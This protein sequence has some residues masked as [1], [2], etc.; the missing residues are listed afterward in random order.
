[1]EMCDFSAIMAVIRAYISQDYIQNQVDFLYMLFGSF[2]A[3][4]ENA[5]FDFDNAL[6]CR[7]MNGTARVSPR[8]TSYYLNKTHRVELQKD[9]AQ[10]VLPLMYDSARA[11]E[12]LYELV[13]QDIDI[14][15]RQ[16][17]LLT[18]N[19]PCANAQEEAVFLTRLLCFAM[20][21]NFVKRDSGTKRLL[22]DGSLSPVAANVI[23][24]ADVPSPCRFF[25]GRDKELSILH[26]TLQAKGKVFLAG[27]A[28][29]GKSELAKAYAK[30]YRK[31]YTNM[32][33][34]TYSGDL[35]QDITD[36]D[37]LDDFSNDTEAERFRKHHRFL[38]MLKEDSLL[39]VDNFNATATQDDF[40]SAMLGYRC[41]ILFTTRSRLE[42]Y[43][44]M[45]LAEISDSTALLHFVARYFP[46]APEHETV[47][48]EIIRTVHA[49]TLAVELA[50]RLLG[51][52]LLSP[53]EL[54]HKLRTEH[55]AL[56]A[57]DKIGITKDGKARKETY[58]GHIHM[59]FSL[60]LLNNKQQSLMRNLS[61]FPIAGISVRRMAEWLHLRNLND[62][63]ELIEMGFVT[64]AAGHMIRL[65][66]MMQEIAIADL[67]P[68]VKKCKML[69]TNLQEIC[70]AHGVDVPYFKPLFQTVENIIA[71]IEKDEPTFFL[72]FLEDVFP[73][74]EKYQ[75]RPGMERVLFALETAVPNY[76][77]NEDRALLLDYRATMEKNDQKAIK[78]EKDALALIPE[79]NASNAL[80]VSN[81]HSNLGGL[82]AN[83]KQYALAS[84]HMETG[85]CILE[86]YQPIP[87]HDMIAKIASYAML[88]N[89]M[90]HP[91]KGFAI[92]EKMAQG[93][94]NNHM[95]HSGD[96]AMVLEAM[97]GICLSQ[98][99]IP[100]GTSYLR[101][102]LALFEKVCG[103]DTELM[104]RKKHAMI[105]TYKSSGVNLN[106]W[107]EG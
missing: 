5:D 2:M 63:D 82:Y 67:K 46:E 104:E 74:M 43:E 18:E 57:E 1:M 37:F 59:L 86:E 102:S 99:K 95:E 103:G 58:Y 78:Y 88:Q 44:N 96:Y 73:Y 89:N 53:Q 50:A 76:G 69:L 93:L 54:M 87:R 71:Y 106:L 56:D 6:V 64:P 49:H 38:R 83:I 33:Y 10:H 7:W 25:C 61:L 24:N 40:L 105:Q 65:H 21:R 72:R 4:K 52:G 23:A 8:I 62:V 17:R 60:Y 84:E 51:K 91:E 70:L 26:E 107:L 42:H 36:L 68:S 92:L 19:Y 94:Q 47:L 12:K 34:L 98:G 77:T 45:E 97:G 79:I 35:K 41:R 100:E 80:L 15:D 22:T 85:L 20:E 13:I 75:Y 30:A 16:K 48:E 27:I 11:M 55:V 28:G 81:L 9:V 90:K 14:S 66:P 39:I 29:I 31:E 32:L 101:Q 3:A